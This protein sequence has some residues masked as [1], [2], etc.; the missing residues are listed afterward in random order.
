MAQ[1]CENADSQL[2][3]LCF[4]ALRNFILIPQLPCKH[5]LHYSSP[6]I[7]QNTLIT[8]V[9]RKLNFLSLC[10][11][12]SYRV[13]RTIAHCADYVLSGDIRRFPGYQLPL[14]LSRQ[15]ADTIARS[16][17]S[18]EWGRNAHFIPCFVVLYY[19]NFF[20]VTKTLHQGSS[21]Q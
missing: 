21:Q 18:A 16:R 7:P 14:R 6:Q 9:L 8:V 13:L 12:C 11:G 10:K 5:R 15:P 19:L 4:N 20:K 1:H 3:D 2:Q 17:L